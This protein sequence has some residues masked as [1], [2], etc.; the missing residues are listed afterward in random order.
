ML[1]HC[2]TSR[3]GTIVDITV[4]LSLL[5]ICPEYSPFYGLNRWHWLG[6][7]GMQMPT[8]VGTEDG[9]QVALSVLMIT[10]DSQKPRRTRLRPRGHRS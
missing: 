3:E 1:Y 6:M 4:T 5:F 2:H 9:V 10:L 8:L 7:H